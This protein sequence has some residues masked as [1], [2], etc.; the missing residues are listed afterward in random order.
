MARKWVKFQLTV[1]QETTLKMWIGSH[2][3]QQRY[4]R[5]THVILLSARGLTLEE[6]SAG[7]GLNRDELSE[8]T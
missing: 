7:S 4:S 8:V 6:I 1:E 2:R 5:R 3:T